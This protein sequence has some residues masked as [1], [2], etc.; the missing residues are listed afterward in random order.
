MRD[1]YIYLYETYLYKTYLYK[2]MLG[3]VFAQ[4]A[5]DD[6]SVEV[7]DVLIF[8]VTVLDDDR[9]DEV[10]VNDGNLVCRVDFC[11]VRS[12]MC[13]HSVGRREHCAGTI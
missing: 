3:G 6:G 8:L 2:R 13:R 12:I 4:S 5:V 7:R 11:Q 9:R 10:C 1:L